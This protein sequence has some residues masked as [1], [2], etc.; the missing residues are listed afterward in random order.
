[1]SFRVWDASTGTVYDAW[2]ESP[3]TFG[4]NSVVGTAST[5]VIFDAE[6][7]VVQNI[8][9]TEGW[10]WVSFNVKSDTP[11]LA[12]ILKNTML[13]GDE[14]V[15]DEAMGSFA[16]YD[17]ESKTWLGNNIVFDNKHMYLIQSSVT[18]KLSVSGIAIKE[19]EDL[20]IPVANNWNYI[21]YLPM[22]NLPIGEALSGYN[23]KEG[24]IVK[25]QNAFSMYGVKTGWLGNLTYMEPGK[26]YML[27]N[28]GESTSLVYPDMM[29]GSGLRSTGV[30]TRSGDAMTTGTGYA[31]TRFEANMSV[32]ATVAESLPVYAGDKLQAYVGGELRGEALL[33]EDPY[34][35]RPLYFVSIGGDR[36][37]SVSFALERGGEI[38]AETSPMFDYRV[39][40]VQG[41]IEQ[42]VI[43]DFV[44]DLQISVY[45]NPFERE[46]NFVMN[47]QPGDKVGIYLYT[48]AGQMIHR[49]SETS[50]N[51]GYLHYRWECYEDLART[52]YMAVV[53]VNGQKHVYK[54]KRK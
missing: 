51:G 15:K 20:T 50:V 48:M 11:D 27:L 25:S 16:A 30:L 29:G 31:D 39:N 8:N 40:N 13:A 37:E 24:D 23:A 12:T 49:H 32:V 28:N 46:L 38:I 34:D 19:K 54:V 52:V 47:T 45:P 44:N 14:Q 10:N 3:I 1:M 53:V 21:S 42:P 5:P 4:S 26:G 18:Q 2:S 33:T 35:G 9:L 43:L 36:N 6:E 7:R 22:T 17:Q 41:S